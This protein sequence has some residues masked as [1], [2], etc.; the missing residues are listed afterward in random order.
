MKRRRDGLIGFP[1]I[2][3]RLRKRLAYVY[4]LSCTDPAF[5]PAEKREGKHKLFSVHAVAYYRS[6]VRRWYNTP[7]H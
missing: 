5:P 4:F 3:R 1:E 7:Q 6:N 2:A